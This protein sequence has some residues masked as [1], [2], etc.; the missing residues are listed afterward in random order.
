[1]GKYQRSKSR[2]RS[3]RCT[4][5]PLANCCGIHIHVCFC[6][7][8]KPAKHFA[9]IAVPVTCSKAAPRNPG[10]ER[11]YRPLAGSTHA[12]VESPGRRELSGRGL[13][14]HIR[15]TRCSPKWGQARREERSLVIPIKRRATRHGPVLG[16]T[17][18]LETT[19]GDGADLA[20]SGVPPR[21]CRMTTSRSLRLASRQSGHQR[22]DQLCIDRP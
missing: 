1:M 17:P 22:V 16:A 7:S 3:F 2:R 20:R 21:S 19:Q 15:S 11:R 10:T 6:R 5:R 13:L 12:T 9:H 8:K 4:A 14:T 18:F